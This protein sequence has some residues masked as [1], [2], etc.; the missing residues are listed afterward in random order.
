MK[1]FP[2]L[3]IAVPNVMLPKEGVDL[4]KWAVIACDQ[5]TSDRE[6]WQEV[7][8]QVGG[9][10][11]TLNVIFPEVYLNDGDGDTRIP[12]IRGTMEQYVKDGVLVEKEGLIYLERQAGGA[13]RKGLV[14]CMD[15]EAY[16][17]NKGSSSLIRATEGTILDRLP[18]RVKI[19]KGAPIELPHI[20]VL[21]DDPD[22]TVIGPLTSAKG[23]LEKVYD[24][25]LMLDSGHLTGYRVNDEQLEK[26][27]TDALGALGEPEKFASR[28]GLSSDMPVLLYA[29][30]DGNH[31]LATAKAIWETAKEEASDKATV[32][33]SPLRY[34]LVELVNLH[35]ESL[36]FE[37]IHR[38]LFELKEGRDP[39]FEMQKAFG[40]RCTV[41]TVDAQDV[42]VKEVDEQ[43]GDTHKIGVITSAGF[44]VVSVTGSNSNLPVGTL[45][46]FLDG[47]MKDAG[48]GELDYVHETEPTVSLGVKEGNIAF[49]LPAMQKADL[50]KSVALDGALPRKTFS[51]GESKDKRFYMEARSLNE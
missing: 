48:A 43:T 32:M 10:P 14:V 2:N 38:V 24:F 40:D 1:K 8:D 17:Y 3:G 41:A 44:R 22:D 50:F 39:A 31:S 13:T 37:P 45:Q 47:F 25:D 49:Y 46:G 16:D 23:N 33:D 36:V 15:L 51:M 20:M 9:A 5:F 28:Y 34:A 11:S 29:M 19:R 42:M 30:G 12:Q 26:G 27:I 6:Y 7:K 35:D 18:P 21:V 4:A